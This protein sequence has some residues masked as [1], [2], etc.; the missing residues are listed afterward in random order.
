MKLLDL[1]AQHNKIRSELN[2]TIRRI[3]DS[4]E[5]ILGED[6]TLLEKEIAD[7]CGTKF[8]VGLNSGTDALIYALRAYGIGSGDE[9]ITTP[10]TFIASAECITLEHAKPVLVDVDEK[11]YNIDPAKIEAKITKRTKAI[12]PVHLF[13]QPAEMDS[14]LAIAKKYNLI[15][16]EDSAQAIGAKYKNQKTC[17]M[18]NV[19]C[20]SFFPAKN[21][22][23]LGDAGMITTN[24]PDLAEKIRMLANHGSKKKYYHEIIGDSSRLDNLQAAILRLKLKYLEQWN[25]ERIEK[26]SIYN[27]LLKDLPIITPYVPKHITSVYQQYTIRSSKRDELRTYLEQKSIPTAIHYP[28]PVHLQPSMKYLGYS[29]K[30]FSVAEK[31][32]KEVLSLP[33][34][35]EIPLSDQETIVKEIKNFFS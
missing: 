17:S 26:V 32:S 7:F 20:L 4:S 13:G 30:D 29:K 16:I 1:N 31:L 2:E 5:F 14:I 35:P 10:F 11:T 25:K 19:G 24:D 33:I 34:Y 15:V 3:I 23:A 21:L 27:S 18:G 9:V 6:N 12:I 8:A 28:T 22:G